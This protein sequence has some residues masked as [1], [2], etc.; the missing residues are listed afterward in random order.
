MRNVNR[1]KYILSL[2]LLPLLVSAQ[3]NSFVINHKKDKFG[4]GTKTWQIK[5]YD[6]N[7]IFFANKNGV[8]QYNGDTWHLYPLR[9]GSDARSLYISEKQGRIYVGGESEFGYLE[10]DGTG[11]LTY[12]PLSAAFNERYNLFGG[13]WGVFEL[14][15]MIYYVSD[16]HVVKQINETFTSIESE[17][18]IDCSAVING[19]LY[20]GTFNGIW[21]LVGN[22]WIPAQGSESVSNKTIR[23]IVPYKNGYLAATAFD[24]LFYGTSESVNPITT[25][26]EDFMRRNEIFSLAATDTHIAV[27]TIHKGLLLIDTETASFSYYNEQNG[28]QNNTVLSICFDKTGDLWLGLDNGID[29]ISLRNSLTNLYTSPYSKGAGYA[30]L[31]H[32]ETLYLGTNRGLYHIPYPV[33]KGEDAINPELIPELS[34]QV[35]GLGKAGN[36]VFCLHDKGLFLIRGT[37]VETIPSFRGALICHPLENEPNR[38]WIGSY[39][40]L[41]MIEKKNGKWGIA[42]RVE[43][44]SSWMKY[45]SFE[46]DYTIWI[47]EVQEGMTRIEI[48]PVTLQ[49]KGNAKIFNETNG[50]E[51]IRDLHAHSLFGEIR[52]STFSGM[53]R[54]DDS[55]GQIVKDEILNAFLLPG[56]S[57]FKMET[58]DSTLYALSYDMIQT[59]R[60]S[61]GQ[62]VEIKYF[63]FGLSQLDFIRD[64]EAL[65]PVN[66]TLAFIP[67]EYGFALLDTELS[68][69]QDR[70]ELFIQNVYTSYPKG[71]LIYTDNLIGF[72]DTPRIPY[73][74]NSLRF[75]YAVRSF[76]RLENIQYRYRLLPDD[77]WSEFTTLKI[78][79]YSNLRE[80]DYTFEV[81][82]N[83][84]DGQ[85]AI[86]K[87]AFTILPPW[88]RTIYAWAV[89]LLLFLALLYA[90]YRWEDRRITRK[91]KAALAQKEQE[92]ILK[93]QEY[94]Q[95]R[96]RK[97]KEIIALQTEKLEQELTFKSQEMANLMIHFSR[98]NEILLALKQ[99]ILKITGE[100]KGDGS[101][102]TKR[103]LLALNNS[104]DS[105]IESDDA[106]KR[107]EEQFNLV[108]NNFMKKVRD[109]HT[110]L[111][112]SEIKMCAYVKMGLSSKEIAPLLNISIRGAETLRYRLRKK[113]ELG[114]ED[115]LT[116]YLNSFV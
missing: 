31:I 82:V 18:K 112:T 2:L 79:E 65:F 77:L 106:L 97:E 75:E 108:H 6:N 72:K 115:S 80:G 69:T 111:T 113:M 39:D 70:K 24:G 13:Y 41:Y 50:F 9:S 44:I 110:D 114:R 93:E 35:W 60:F 89:Y 27:G 64:Y 59:L 99:D 12:T 54:Y 67:N 116:E 34:G 83:L 95:E 28:L 66:N 49:R 29:Y 23:A 56:Q 22:T 91:R 45:V 85:N 3:W 25:G 5:T 47:R 62:P 94:D 58:S 21:M 48:D 96:I 10:P 81:E 8:L 37:T 78:K 32:N 103:M 102:K 74:R 76:G 52:F 68:A 92:M 105:N 33:K 40:G 61:D 98:K 51:T 55:T 26:A 17:F 1:I 107:F 14:D 15:N 38:C 11:Q 53:Y 88:Y 87:Y 46:S 71:S 20:V 4:R 104:I 86:E 57:Y 42:G 7:H 63:P 90:L 100:M 16:H 19:V 84:P 73:G 36:D 109:K 43:G 101:I 30:A